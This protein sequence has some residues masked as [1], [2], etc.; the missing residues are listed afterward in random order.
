MSKRYDLGE[1][2]HEVVKELTTKPRLEE[3]LAQ[4]ERARAVLRLL[5]ASE[6]AIS[7]TAIGGEITPN[8]RGD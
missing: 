5:R 2:L 4:R 8:L 1:V 7:R 6:I 3:E